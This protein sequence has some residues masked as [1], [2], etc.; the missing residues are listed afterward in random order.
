MNGG[1]NFSPVTNFPDTLINH[2]GGLLAVTPHDPDIVLVILLTKNMNN[3]PFIYQGTNKQGNWTWIRK[4]VG[5]DASF[6]SNALTNGQG[7]FDL[8][9]EIS[10]VNKNIVYAGTTTLFKSTNGGASFS[11]VGGYQG[12]FGIHPDIQDMK[13]LANGDTW[14]ATDGGMNLSTNNFTTSAA[15]FALNKMLVGSDLW[16][17]HQGWNEDIIVG[18]RYH[19]G[20]TSIT[21]FYGEKAL[22]MG[23]GE[24]PTGWVI[25]GK[26]RHV[27]FDDLGSGW[28]LP[29]TAEGKPEGR[30]TFSKHPNMEGYGAL[31]S[32]VVAHPYYS[33]QLYVGSENALWV[34]K[35]FG[36][37]FD[38]LYDFGS[39]V[40][41]FDISTQN[42]DVIYVDV[43]GSGFF[44]SED[45]GTFAL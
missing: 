8:V 27:V 22:R 13:L 43:A 37:T 3:R 2:S 21:D 41:Y 44:R 45:G 1:K 33:G 15:H 38:L 18:G 31:R 5:S 4:F 39:K 19:N 28:I 7:Y 42:P 34:S 32:N 11:A 17:F 14:V 23:G 12:S 6:T 36:S 9:L 20:N 16:G 26:S 10:P 24:S 35:D 29:K 25:Q 40:R 30:F